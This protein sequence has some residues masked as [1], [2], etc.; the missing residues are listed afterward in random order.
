MTT[1]PHDPA[2]IARFIEQLDTIA[3]FIRASAEH[4]LEGRPHGLMQ[5]IL[6]NPLK[7]GE[8]L[9]SR[10][11]A[12]REQY[13][14]VNTEKIRS[15]NIS[16]LLGRLSELNPAPFPGWIRKNPPS[17]HEWV[18]NQPSDEPD[19][20]A[21]EIKNPDSP[22]EAVCLP[23]QRGTREDGPDGMNVEICWGRGEWKDWATPA[24]RTKINARTPELCPTE[25]LD[26]D[27]F[28][29]VADCAGGFLRG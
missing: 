4:E 14:S 13:P 26:K 8:K 2:D 19:I 15:R 16:S 3:D 10:A 11:S 24:L 29:I 17:A 21:W 5:E 18:S 22:D 25:T 9:A 28:H 12:Y 6:H 7:E 1:T 20:D 23:I 27:R